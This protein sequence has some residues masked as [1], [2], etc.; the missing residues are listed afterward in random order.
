[1]RRTEKPSSQFLG[2]LHG[3]A[4]LRSDQRALAMI[5]ARARKRGIMAAVSRSSANYVVRRFA[6]EWM[7]EHADPLL[8]EGHLPAMTQS[9][10]AAIQL[11]AS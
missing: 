8:A 6:L 3:Q 10:A 11:R 4:I 5:E 7:A 2:L 9:N 1:M